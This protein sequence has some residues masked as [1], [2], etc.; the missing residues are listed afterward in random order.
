MYTYVAGWDIPRAQW[1]DMEK[2]TRLD[3]KILDKAIADGTIVGYGNDVT[4]V[5]QADG[6]NSRRLVVGD[7]HGRRA[8]RAGPVG[9]VRRCYFSRP[10]QRHGPCG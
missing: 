9:K 6:I 4:L 10:C 8:Q 2:A 7:V 1:A 3:Q 5:H